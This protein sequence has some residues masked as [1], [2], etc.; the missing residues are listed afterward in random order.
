MLHHSQTLVKIKM[1]VFQVQIHDPPGILSMEWES[2]SPLTCTQWLVQV[3]VGV[4]TGQGGA[5]EQRLLTMKCVLG[6]LG[7]THDSMAVIR[8]GIK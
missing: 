8:S 3:S 7:K 4:G 6:S 5:V 1:Y 2:Q